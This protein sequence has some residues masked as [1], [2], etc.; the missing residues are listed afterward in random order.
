MGV[1]A[2]AVAL[3]SILAGLGVA[4]WQ[5]RVA[6]AERA[7]A[8]RRFDEARRLIQTVIFDIQ[9]K[10]G[11]VP[12]TTPLRKDLI[13]STLK[14][15]E[16]LA[17]DAGDNPALLRELAG[18]YVQ[19]ARVQGDANTSNV[20]D[21]E[22]ART[23]LAAA[24]ALTERLLA[25]DPTGPESLRQAIAVRRQLAS[26]WQVARDYSRAEAE[27]RRALALAERLVAMQPRDPKARKDLADSLFSVA[28][29]TDSVETYARSREVY[30]SLLQETP[31]EP[32]HRR[33]VA[34]IHKYVASIHYEKG[35]HR[36]ALD[37]M[38]KARQIDESLLAA[39]PED[40]TAQ[41][42]LAIDLSQL[43]E[44]YSK[45]GDLPLAVSTMAESMAM[46]ERIVAA[47]PADARALDRLAYALRA[48]ARLREKAGDVAAA[49]RDYERSAGI[50]RDL[51]GRAYARESVSE[52]LA[53]TTLALGEI[54]TRAGREA[55]ACGNYR[56]AAA[57]Y[58]E[59][60]GTASPW[61]KEQAGKSRR[62]A[63]ACGG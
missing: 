29:I 49:R 8:Q 35:D 32:R 45:L 30:E 62:L 19:L 55:A 37:L 38:L 11:A 47:N 5:A 15:L 34:L 50:D 53:G 25:A 26:H 18:S 22:G 51:R 31:D 39:R 17:K 42:D 60:P 16:A 46:R 52:R 13:E 6:R 28:N 41:M 3:A 63:A 40:P 61:H 56:E 44:G 21:S 43:S 54:E 9:P 12:G 59:L 14:Y 7:L 23:T 36:S 27:A 24:E 1:I 57:L 4:L 58:A 10:L 2:G 33:A 20:G 48:L